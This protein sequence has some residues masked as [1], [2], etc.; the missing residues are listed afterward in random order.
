MLVIAV[1]LPFQGRRLLSEASPLRP[2]IFASSLAASLRAGPAGH[3][4]LLSVRALIEPMHHILS[5]PA[6]RLEKLFGNGPI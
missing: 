2:S 4:Y 6:A 1:K 3:D 5:S